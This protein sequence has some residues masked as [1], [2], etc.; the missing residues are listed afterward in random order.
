MNSLLPALKRQVIVPHTPERRS[1]ASLKMQLLDLET[2]CQ[3]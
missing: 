3:Q 1:L 2:I